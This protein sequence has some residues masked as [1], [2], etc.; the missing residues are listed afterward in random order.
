MFLPT[1]H[2]F[3]LQSCCF[4]AKEMHIWMLTNRFLL[5][6]TSQSLQQLLPP[7]HTYTTSSCTITPLHKCSRTPK[8]WSATREVSFAWENQAAIFNIIMLPNYMVLIGNCLIILSVIW[9]ASMWP[10]Q[11]FFLISKVWP[12]LLTQHKLSKPLYTKERPLPPVPPCMQPTPTIHC[13]YLWCRS[14]GSTDARHLHVKTNWGAIQWCSK[15]RE[16]KATEYASS[17]NSADRFVFYTVAEICYKNNKSSVVPNIFFFCTS[18]QMTVNH[19]SN[20]LILI[21]FLSKCYI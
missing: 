2:S 17:R 4:W 5:Q 18:Q 3:I 1:L 13:E 16:S 11:A 19:V 8:L 15:E 9:K 14:R 12:L 10:S 21:D 7:Y 20:V 6:K